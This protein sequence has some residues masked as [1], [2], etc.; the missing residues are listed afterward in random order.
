M[1]YK[2]KVGVLVDFEGPFSISLSNQSLR[3]FR[4]FPE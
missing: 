2:D 4:I 3:K 1:S